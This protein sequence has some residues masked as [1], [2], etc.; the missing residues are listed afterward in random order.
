MT[1]EMFGKLFCR[2]IT[3]KWNIYDGVHPAGVKLPKHFKK[4]KIIQEK[5][6]YSNKNN[7]EADQA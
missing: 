6:K 1:Q 5:E 4:K 7:P 2:L 3:Q